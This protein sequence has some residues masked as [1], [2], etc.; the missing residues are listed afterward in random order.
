MK[1][2]AWRVALGFAVLA[3]PLVALAASDKPDTDKLQGTWGI[4]SAEKAGK[5]AGDNDLKDAKAVF[6]GD[7]FTWALP[8][9]E[10][11]GTFTVDAAKSP[12][13]INIK[14][15]A[16]AVTGIYAIE[17]DN[18]KICLSHSDVRPTEFATRDGEPSM[19]LVLKREKP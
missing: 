2:H 12:K 4:V 5:V 18:L 8:Q 19:L 14:T 9:H 1:K 3:L 16:F 11:T 10:L 7:K 17:G 6:A 15:E 13:Q